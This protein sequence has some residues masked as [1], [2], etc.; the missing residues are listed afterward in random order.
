MNWDAIGAIAEL[1]GAIGVIASLVYL[2]RQMSQNTRAIRASGFQQFRSEISTAWLG[3]LATPGL[4]R[5]ILAG[6]M[7]YDQLDDEAAFQFECWSGAIFAAYD[8]AYYQYR[9]EMLD[10]DRWEIQRRDVA[11]LFHFFPGVAQY[12]KKSRPGVSPEFVAL[13]S[14]PTTMRHL[15]CPELL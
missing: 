10:A 14:L 3:A 6:L 9:T 4:T 8:N 12:W 7:D 5:G 11:A 2:A 13:P 1:L 15:T